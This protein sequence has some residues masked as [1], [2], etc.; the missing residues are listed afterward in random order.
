M[1]SKSSLVHQFI[2]VHFQTVSGAKFSYLSKLEIIDRGSKHWVFF[3]I[4][5][6]NTDITSA[7]VSYASLGKLHFPNQNKIWNP[8]TGAVSILS[9]LGDISQQ[10]K[11]CRTIDSI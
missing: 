3:S 7:Q 10:Q 9:S 4:L 5:T 1:S 8:G 6:I 11:T 2:N